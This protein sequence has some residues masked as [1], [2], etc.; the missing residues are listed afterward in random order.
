MKK[1]LLASTALVLSAGVAAA[2]MTVSGDG[3]MGIINNFDPDN[4]ITF[5]SRFRAIFTGSGET[6]GGLSFGG[7]I[8]AD[9]AGGIT[10]DDISGDGVE[11]SDLVP[12]GGAAGVAGSVF[13]SGDF[14]TLSMGDVSGAPEAAVGDVSG[15]GLTGLGDLN[16][17]TYLSNAT[18]GSRSAARYDYS[19]GDF[20]F[21]VSADNPVAYPTT[22]G[23]DLRTENQTYGV[24]VTYSGDWF[25]AGLGYETRD[26]TRGTSTSANGIRD[27]APTGEHIIGGVSVDFAGAT[28]KGIYGQADLDQVGGTLDQYGVSIDYT[29]DAA[30]LTAFYVG[31]DE[32]LKEEG[33]GLGVSYDLGGGASV[34]GGYVKSETRDE[35]AFDFGV[36]MRF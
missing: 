22:A 24:A 23:G 25:S 9:N 8:R 18:A 14:G 35:D 32:E 36:S 29:F 6:D 30:T 1:V 5:T 17:M 2:D 15:V 7:T 26:G 27:L 31:G 12:G 4:T 28:L 11:A 16:E 13:I 34:K 19:F 20:G 21:H 33:Y 3:R 10:V